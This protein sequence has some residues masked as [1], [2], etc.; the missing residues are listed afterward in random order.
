M[1]RRNDQAAKWITAGEPYRER[2]AVVQSDWSIGQELISLLQ[3]LE[4]DVVR[5][6]RER[7]SS[8]SKSGVCCIL[9]ESSGASGHKAQGLA[10]H[11][12]A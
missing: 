10:G 7:R 2:R 1:T 4:E 11:G 5:G 3:P 6:K 8:G 12:C 9:G